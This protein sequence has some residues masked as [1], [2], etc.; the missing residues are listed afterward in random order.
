MSIPLSLI[1]GS[2]F[3]F[4]IQLDDSLIF[5]SESAQALAMHFFWP[6]GGAVSQQ[7]NPSTWGTINISTSPVQVV[8]FTAL[9]FARVHRRGCN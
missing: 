3:G 5:V 1:P 8:I 4:F 6:N 9:A 7:A 2:T